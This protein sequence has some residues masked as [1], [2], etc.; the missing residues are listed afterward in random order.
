MRR[1]QFF[2]A[3]RVASRFMWA[4]LSQKLPAL[5]DDAIELVRKEEYAEAFLA[6]DKFLKGLGIV[7]TASS[8]TLRLSGSWV[9]NLPPS[10]QSDLNQWMDKISPIR[11]QL[12]RAVDPR[13]RNEMLSFEDIEWDL[14]FLKHNFLPWVEPFFRDEA[15]EFTHGPFK[16]VLMHGA[17]DGLEEALKTLDAACDRIKR[18]SALAPV[19]YGKVHIVRGIQ[20]NKAGSYVEVNDT[21]NLSL[22]ATPQRD[23]VTTLIHEFGHRY[24]T[25]FMD[26][27]K[28]DRFIRLSTEGDFEDLYFPVRDRQRYAEEYVEML[29]RHRNEDFESGTYSDD[30][31]SWF[32]TF[33][34]EEFKRVAPLIRQFRDDR[35]ESVL[36]DLLNALGKLQFRGNLRAETNPDKRTPLSAS[37]YGATSWSENFAESFLAYV[38][39]WDLPAPL[40]KFLADL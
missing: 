24:H 4:K 36:P 40:Q 1:T 37:A 13:T 18:K 27:A 19:L 23:S 22:Y 31:K 8:D 25:R 2:L 15:D 26:K 29:R 35:D 11:G 12:R 20:G 14:G 21:I 16:V 7:G 32:A 28:R 34:R 3:Q 30:A 9:M 6:F 17:G 39:G 10:E 33:P 38:M 5:L